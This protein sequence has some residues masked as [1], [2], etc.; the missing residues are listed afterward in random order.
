M[1][2]FLLLIILGLGLVYADCSDGDDF[3]DDGYHCGDIQVLQDIID[4]NP[5]L[6][7]NPL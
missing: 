1:R 4:V 7:G 2:K 5:S 3:N 6:S